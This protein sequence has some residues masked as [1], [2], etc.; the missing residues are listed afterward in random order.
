MEEKHAAD[1]VSG[2]DSTADVQLHRDR[3]RNYLFDF[4]FE[5]LERSDD[6]DL[7]KL[8]EPEKSIFDR[9]PAHK[10]GPVESEEYR[11]KLVEMGEGLAHHYEHNRHHPEHFENG[12][13]GMNLLDI[14]EMVA[15]WKAAAR[16][17]RTPVNLAHLAERFG[18]DGQLAAILENTLQE[19]DS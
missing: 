17:S 18:I 15:D 19:M 14:L 4:I 9:Y 1:S 2:Y 16:A 8:T 12:I 13:S 5:L 10:S 7:S 6:H 3:V 11:A